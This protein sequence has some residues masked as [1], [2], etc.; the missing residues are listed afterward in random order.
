ML[1]GVLRGAVVI[2]FGNDCMLEHV[3]DVAI[4]V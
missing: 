4:F 2:Q 3:S 1:K